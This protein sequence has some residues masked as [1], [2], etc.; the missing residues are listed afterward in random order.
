MELQRDGGGWFSLFLEGMIV[1]GDACFGT[2]EFFK[3][4]ERWSGAA[5]VGGMLVVRDS[6]RSQSSLSHRLRNR[7][8][9]RT[10]H[11]QEVR[12]AKLLWQVRG[13]FHICTNAHTR[14]GY[15]SDAHAGT[16]D[17]GPQAHML[18]TRACYC[19]VYVCMYVC[20][21]VCVCTY[22]TGMHIKLSSAK[23]L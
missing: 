12:A 23:L 16:M 15:A 8:Q 13:R 11:S 3:V 7:H 17:N 9:G 5:T 22:W 21:C 14:S 10:H 4:F 19:F 20:V 6:I 1:G 2:L 18:R